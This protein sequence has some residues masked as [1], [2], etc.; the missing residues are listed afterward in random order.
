MTDGTDLAADVLVGADGSASRV[1]AQR[2]PGLQVIDIGQI[3]IFGRTPLS[4]DVLGELPPAALDGFCIV[5]GPD[6]RSMPLAAHRF[7]HPPQAA[8][9]ELRPGLRLSTGQDYLMWVL[10]LPD[11][12]L[13]AG[14]LPADLVDFVAAQVG[15]WH[16]TLARLVSASQPGSVHAT[17][18]R[19][20]RR[21]EPWD[22]GPVTLIG[23][24]AHPMIPAGIGAAVALADAAGLAEDL[25]RVARGEAGLLDAVAGYEQ[26]MRCYAFDAVEASEQRLS[27]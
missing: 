10:A 25:G 19:S 26:R 27:G 20:S 13:P 12:F 16:P 5:I 18:V 7:A 15:P 1:R 9:D 17:T 14:A 24:A 21:P 4:P 23:D 22:A 8:A 11:R 2:I 6:G 3:N